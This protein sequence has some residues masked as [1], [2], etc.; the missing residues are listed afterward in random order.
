[1]LEIALYQL[2]EQSFLCGSPWTVEQFKNCLDQD[3]TF[4]QISQVNHQLVGFAIGHVN[5]Y[6]IELYLIATHPYYQRKGIASDLILAVKALAE[7]G[8]SIFLEVR[9]SNS[10]ARSFYQRHNFHEIGERPAYYAGP[11]ENAIQLRWKE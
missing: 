2:A 5:P 7:K 3:H 6:E 4:I 1:M 9:K 11:I 10:R 8:Q